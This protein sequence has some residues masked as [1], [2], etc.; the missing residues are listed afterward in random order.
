MKL[1][2]ERF[3]FLARFQ[4]GSLQANRAR[5]RKQV[6]V[7]GTLTTHG[8]QYIYL[9]QCQAEAGRGGKRGEENS[10]Y[11]HALVDTALPPTPHLFMMAF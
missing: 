11:P 6:W 3:A 1:W 10:C 7:T 4:A 8:V 5:C 9:F 2:T